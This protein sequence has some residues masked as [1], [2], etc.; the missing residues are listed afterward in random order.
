MSLLPELKVL[1]RCGIHQHITR[2]IGQLNQAIKA[3]GRES[4]SHLNERKWR[5]LLQCLPICQLPLGHRQPRLRMRALCCIQDEQEWRLRVRLKLLFVSIHAQLL[6]PTCRVLGAQR[7]IRSSGKDAPP[8]AWTR[9]IDQSPI[10]N[11]L[12]S[13]STI[14]ESVATTRGLATRKVEGQR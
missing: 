5:S 6:S 3:S 2:S 14:R 4:N 11:D 12:P 1:A 8:P 9:S 13:M 10:Q 7:S